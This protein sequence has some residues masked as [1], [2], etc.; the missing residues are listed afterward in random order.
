MLYKL[1]WCLK[2]WDLNM[3]VNKNTAKIILDAV[4]QGFY[5]ESITERYQLKTLHVTEQML[6]NMQ[7]KACKLGQKLCKDDINTFLINTKRTNTIV[8]NY[9]YQLPIQQ[10]LYGEVLRFSCIQDGTVQYIELMKMSETDFLIIETSI[11]ELEKH[12]YLSLSVDSEITCN[13][14]MD[15]SPIGHITITETN[16][17][18][19]SMYYHYMNHYF[20]EQFHRYEVSHNLW[21]R[22]NELCD[23]LETK[24]KRVE[25]ENTLLHFSKDGLST[26]VVRKMIDS[27]MRFKII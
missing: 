17:V 9:W 6:R 5:Y 14:Q 26:F 18:K 20:F 19:P 10:I 4:Y 12:G 22:Y 23:L 25:F 21:P 7:D 24:L 27:I 2:N 8:N 3:A 16:H 1:D 13:T 11:L 15:L